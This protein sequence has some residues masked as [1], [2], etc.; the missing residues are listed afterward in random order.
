MCILTH[1]KEKKETNS[2]FEGGQGPHWVANDL[3]LNTGPE[4]ALGPVNT[5]KYM[6]VVG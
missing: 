3:G 6:S 2:W 4:V 1:Q 5:W